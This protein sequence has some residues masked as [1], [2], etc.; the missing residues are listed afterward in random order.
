MFDFPNWFL[1]LKPSNIQ[2]PN[3]KR[4]ECSKGKANFVISPIDIWK[5]HKNLT[6]YKKINRMAHKCVFTSREGPLIRLKS[7][8]RLE[9]KAFLLIRV[10][11]ST[12]IGILQRLRKCS[13]SINK[14]L[15]QTSLVE[16]QCSCLQDFLC[17]PQHV[18]I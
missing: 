11:Q 1:L 2:K 5:F 6:C 18:F 8:R 13:T 15:K 3:L 12:Q 16:A 10:V 4:Q 9:G 14:I 7:G 17:L